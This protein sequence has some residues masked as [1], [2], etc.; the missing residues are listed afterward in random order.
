[1]RFI[2][3]S[4]DKNLLEY[5]KTK[6]VVEV[7]RKVAKSC[8]DAGKK[9]DAEQVAKYFTSRIKLSPVNLE[10][11]A[12]NYSRSKGI[13]IDGAKDQLSAVDSAVTDKLPLKPDHVALL[14]DT[15][16]F[17]T[18]KQLQQTFLAAQL[19]GIF[20]TY[21]RQDLYLWREMAKES[22]D[23]LEKC[24]YFTELSHQ[25][26]R[27]VRE[28]TGVGLLYEYITRM[29][30]KVPRALQNRNPDESKEAR[31]K[32]LLEVDQLCREALED[33]SKYF[34]DGCYMATKFSQYSQLNAYKY[35]V[36]AAN[37]RL[38]DEDQSVLP[39]DAVDNCIR[40]EDLAVQ[41]ISLDMA[42]SCIIMA[43]KFYASMQLFPITFAAFRAGLKTTKDSQVFG[44][45]QQEKQR[46]KLMAWT[47]YNFTRAVKSYFKYAGEANAQE[48][49]NLK[50]EALSLCRRALDLE[51]QTE[52]WKK[53]MQ[54]CINGLGDLHWI[55]KNIPCHHCWQL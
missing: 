3:S 19:C 36:K 7:A 13:P 28:K 30:N 12:E 35:M 45:Y 24:T 49:A 32:R 27:H 11:F 41:Q 47:A 20:H 6:S 43:A 33:E 18:A 9:I 15:G 34:E 26:A 4:P 42:P 10:E 37:K 23:Y 44:V 39:P 25:V 53:N 16:N 40:M 54:E 50:N 46:P 38:R 14:R 1:L 21:G 22:K 8:S 55:C 52:E 31:R 17:L 29:N 5:Q 48:K 51:K 2:K